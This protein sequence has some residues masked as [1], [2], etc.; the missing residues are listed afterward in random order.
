M[1]CQVSVKTKVTL[2]S[3]APGQFTFESRGKVNLKVKNYI[4]AV[5]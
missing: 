5:L 4:L 3:M 2:E 1:T